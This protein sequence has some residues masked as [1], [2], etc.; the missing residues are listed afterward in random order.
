MNFQITF[1]DRKYEIA[2]LHSIISKIKLLSTIL[3]DNF[4]NII[5]PFLCGK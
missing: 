1:E 4:L 3:I 5:K 2:N